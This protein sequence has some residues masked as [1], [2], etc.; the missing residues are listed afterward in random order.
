MAAGAGREQLD[1]PRI[2]GIR[3]R[4]PRGPR[5][6]AADR[7]LPVAAAAAPAGTRAGGAKRAG[8]HGGQEGCDHHR[9]PAE[10]RPRTARRAGHRRGRPAAGGA[11]DL[12]SHGP[13][14]QARR[15][16]PRTANG[17]TTSTATATSRCASPCARATA[18]RY[19]DDHDALRLVERGLLLPVDRSPVQAAF[20]AEI[21]LHGDLYLQPLR[22]PTDDPATA[23]QRARDR[24]R[25]AVTG[26]LSAAQESFA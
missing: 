6:P 5:A 3:L 14:A 9:A 1:Q 26:L 4:A 12:H 13:S 23:L 24:Y 20:G 2:H 11:A 16:R 7:Q 25:G 21:D 8:D 18:C 22:D 17:W 15:A 10:L 19:A